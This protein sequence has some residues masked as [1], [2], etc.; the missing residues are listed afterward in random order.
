MT[1]SD[2]EG[3]IIAT[4]I[5]MHTEHSWERRSSLPDSRC[6]ASHSAAALSVCHTDMKGGTPLSLCVALQLPLLGLLYNW[7]T[8]GNIKNET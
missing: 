5:I 4:C 1:L 2:R 8:F 6:A 3:R 7:R